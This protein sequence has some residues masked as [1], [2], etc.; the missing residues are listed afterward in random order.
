LSVIVHDSADRA[1]REAADFLSGLT[2]ISMALELQKNPENG[3]K[4]RDDPEERH[5]M[6]IPVRAFYFGLAFPRA[7]T[8]R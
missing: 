5:R 1:R 3:D 4:R 6:A 2:V 8:K 7:S